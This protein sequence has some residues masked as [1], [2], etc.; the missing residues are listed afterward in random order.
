MCR[1]MEKEKSIRIAM[2]VF[3]ELSR[4]HFKQNAYMRTSLSGRHRH[5]DARDTCKMR[6][7]AYKRWSPPCMQQYMRGYL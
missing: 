4:S 6:V 5:V 7:V 2:T 3:A 1:E